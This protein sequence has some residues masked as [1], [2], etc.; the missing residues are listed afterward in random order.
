[1]SINIWKLI[2][3]QD[4]NPYAYSDSCPPNNCTQMVDC[5]ANMLF[6]LS[7]F[8]NYCFFFFF[9]PTTYNVNHTFFKLK[10]YL[11]YQENMYLYIISNLMLTRLSR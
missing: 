4:E 1:M 9:N 11:V 3:Y 10:D 7:S 2:S 6:S 8:S 5:Q